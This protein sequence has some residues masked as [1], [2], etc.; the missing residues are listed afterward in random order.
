LA[1]IVNWLPEYSFPHEAAIRI[2]LPV[3]LFSMVLALVTAVMFGF[4]PA[5]HLSRPETGP[6]DR[7]E[8]PPDYRHRQR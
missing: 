8:H 3:L 6:H 2:N 1:L 5:L 4:S 7:R